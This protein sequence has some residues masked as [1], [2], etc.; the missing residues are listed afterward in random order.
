[1]KN[2]LQSIKHKKYFTDFNESEIQKE[3]N[4]TD[5]GRTLY[6]SL[7]LLKAFNTKPNTENIKQECTKRISEL[8]NK[9]N[10]DQKTLNTFI[11][12]WL[13]SKN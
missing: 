5:D 9:L 4:K 2:L 12:G 3:I 10:I 7:Q 6:L 8:A 1:M 11:K 13:T